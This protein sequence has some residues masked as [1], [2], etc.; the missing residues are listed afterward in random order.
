MDR[1]YEFLGLEPYAHDFNNVEQITKE[2]DSV[3]GIYGDH[4]I[5]NEVKPIKS[6]ALEILG[7]PLCNQIKEKYRWFYETFNY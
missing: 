2:D 1:L 4:N 7:Q 5:R 6:S 3:Y